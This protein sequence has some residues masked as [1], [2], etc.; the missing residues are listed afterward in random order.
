MGLVQVK[1]LL[2]IGHKNQ[3]IYIYLFSRNRR[4]GTKKDKR[5]IGGDGIERGSSVLESG[6]DDLYN[7]FEHLCESGE[8]LSEGAFQSRGPKSREGSLL[9]L[10]MGWWK[11]WE[12]KYVSFLSSW[13][14]L[15]WVYL[16][17]YVRLNI[18]VDLIT[19]CL[20]KFNI[21]FEILN[22]IWE[23]KTWKRL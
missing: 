17:F 23:A 4:I 16:Q 1:G 5:K 9:Y 21:L 3:S 20:I 14:M 18:H 19:C 13:I 22:F 7:L 8:E 15:R 6:G 11:A 12:T 10:Q 2:L